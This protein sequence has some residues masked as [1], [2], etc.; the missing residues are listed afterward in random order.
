MRRKIAFTGANYVFLSFT[1]AFIVFQFLLIIP[2][3]IWGE[4]FLDRY[5]YGV[6][7]VNQ[8]VIIL[9]PVLA[10]TLKEKLDIKSVFR[11]RRPGLVPTLLV[12][13]LTLPASLCAGMLNTLM[14][15][16]LQYV[17]DIPV[18]SFPA[19]QDLSGLFAGILVIAV[20]PALCE[21]LLHRGIMLSA[22]ENRGSYRAVILTAVLFGI[23]HFDITNLLGPIFLGLLIGYYVVRTD[24]IF[25]GMLAHF[26]NNAFSLLI[27]YVSRAEPQGDR[28]LK[29]TE[30]ELMSVVLYGIIGLIVGS[31]LLYFFRLST[32]GRSW[33]RPPISSIKTD[34]L[35]VA[36]H[37][38]III[39]MSLY[40]LFTFITLLSGLLNRLMVS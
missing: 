9:I 32:E 2:I 15:Y 23:F 4:D 12:I 38:P 18:Q 6:L 26:T 10:Y 14:A 34:V 29:V 16:L 1:I 17:G 25:I 21:E 11:L 27:Q 19:P 20:S 30:T 3:S 33:P 36:S 8:Y 22:Y 28:F 40:L 37:W 13:L 7:L 35:A 24:S 31:I 5:M 39:I